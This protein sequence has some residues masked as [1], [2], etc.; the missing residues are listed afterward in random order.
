M[1]SGKADPLA[2]INTMRDEGLVRVMH[3]KA[4]RGFPAQAGLYLP[5]LRTHEKTDRWQVRDRRAF[6]SV[7]ISQVL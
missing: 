6:R 3:E 1:A 2:G 4:W 7:S 5:G